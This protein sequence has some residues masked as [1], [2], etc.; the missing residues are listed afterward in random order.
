MQ[1]A[2]A[3]PGDPVYP[4]RLWIGTPKAYANAYPFPYVNIDGFFVCSTQTTENGRDG[5]IMAILPFEE[6]SEIW[7]VAWEGKMAGGQFVPRQACFRT[8]DNF[9]E[10]GWHKW[11]SNQRVCK[12][13]QV[14]DP[15][16]G[17][18]WSLTCETKHQL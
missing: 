5:E 14:P 2:V 12:H 17:S 11:E 1:L 7:Y 8:T 4:E 13:H 3:M 16:W 10:T 9:W 15:E 18:E 6:G